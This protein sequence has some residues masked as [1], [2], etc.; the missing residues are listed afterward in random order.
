MATFD[1]S[2]IAQKDGKATW[3]LCGIVY[4]EHDLNKNFMRI[5]VVAVFS[6][7]VEVRHVSANGFWYIA[8]L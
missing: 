2:T 6:I 4:D 3:I 8:G 5:L 1:E 7:T